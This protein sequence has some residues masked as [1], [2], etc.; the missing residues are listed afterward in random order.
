MAASPSPEAVF[1]IL[2][3]SNER[4]SSTRPARCGRHRRMA[5]VEVIVLPETG[6]TRRSKVGEGTTDAA[7]LGA[8]CCI[9]VECEPWHPPIVRRANQAPR[10]DARGCVSRTRI[11]VGRVSEGMLEEEARHQLMDNTVGV[12]LTRLICSIDRQMRPSSL[13]AS[14]SPPARECPRRVRGRIELRRANSRG[15]ALSVEE[16][17]VWSDPTLFV[18]YEARSRRRLQLRQSGHQ[19]RPVP[20]RVRSR[21]F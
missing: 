2:A 4:A 3:K 16:S 10:A 8:L 18:R 6:D 21:D 13:R 15:I 12:G 7:T 11:W 19:E 1:T 17:H 9:G 5:V 14:R 20:R